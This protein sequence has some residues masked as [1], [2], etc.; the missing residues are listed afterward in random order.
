MKFR[1]SPSKFEKIIEETGIKNFLIT[2]PVSVFGGTG[3]MFSK[4][5]QYAVVVWDST[6]FR[7]NSPVSVNMD[8]YAT[9]HNPIGEKI[10][11]S[12]ENCGSSM[13]FSDN[14]KSFSFFKWTKAPDQAGG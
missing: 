13:L 2:P 11:A 10:L 12:L 4:D 7:M 14:S 8:L 9:A 3:I 6:E 5:K 1:Y